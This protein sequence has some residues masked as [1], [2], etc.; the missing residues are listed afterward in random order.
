L[1]EPFAM[2]ISGAAGCGKTTLLRA[3]ANASPGQPVLERVVTVEDEQELFLSRDR[4]RNL[5]EFESKEANVDG[6]GDYPMQRYLTE[7]LRRQ[8]PSKVLLGEM[9]PDGGVLPLLLAAGQGIAQGVATTIHAPS[10]A[11]V[12]DRLLIYASFGSRQVPQRTVLQTIASTVDLIVHVAN[13]QGR[14]VV[15]TVREVADYRDGAVTSAELWRWDPRAGRAVRTE[16]DMSDGLSE[17]LSRA[18]IDPAALVRRRP[19]NSR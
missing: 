19:R 6:K 10:A 1:Q 4:F 13:V 7:N 12:V 5:V 15:T 11:D 17:K 8:T 18:R 14:R 16:V 2:V 3:W 9:K